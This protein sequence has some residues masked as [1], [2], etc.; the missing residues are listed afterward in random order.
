M[1]PRQPSGRFHRGR[2]L[3]VWAVLLLLSVINAGARESWL[4]HHMDAESA[5]V[6]STLVLCLWIAAA[7]WLLTPWLQLASERQALRTGLAW[8]ALTMAFESLVGHYL[9]GRPWSALWEGGELKEGHIWPLVLV[10]TAATPWLAWRA[11]R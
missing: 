5:H 10:V 8:V 2:V 11:R 6:L 4:V 3:T 9:L 7:V 1:S